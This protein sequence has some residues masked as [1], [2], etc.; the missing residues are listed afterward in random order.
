MVDIV[1][2][3]DS[4][5]GRFGPLVENA[6][7][8]RTQAALDAGV[9]SAIA[10]MSGLA[11]AVAD[12][13]GAKTTTS[14]LKDANVI[15]SASR[16]AITGWYHVDGFGAKGDGATDDRAAIQAALNAANDLYTRNHKRQSVY[17]PPS[18]HIVGAVDYRKADGSIYGAVSLMLPDGV[19]FFGPGTIRVKSGAYGNGALYAIIR[20]SDA[21]VSTASVKGITLDGNRAGNVGSVQCSNIQLEA[22]TDVEVS[23]TYQLNANGNGIMVRGSI[24]RLATNIR[25]NRNTVNGASAIGIQA[26]QFDGLEIDQNN[27]QGTSDNGID[28]YGENGS[29]T[30]SGINWRISR[31]RVRQAPVGIFIESVAHGICEGNDVT[32]CLSECIHVNRINSAPDKVTISNNQLESSPNG[33]RITGDMGSVYI[34]GN[35]IAGVT[36]GGIHM[37]GGGANLSHIYIDS[38]FI[39]VANIN[40]VPLVLIASNT[41]VWSQTVIRRTITQNTNRAYDV[42]N[43]A[44]TKVNVSYDAA[45]T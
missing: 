19:D 41:N 39:D 5:T 45:N 26:S 2:A 34:R 27:V 14:L 30:S 22:K 8:A 1:A 38:N 7:A 33:I 9:Q 44:T 37:G 6:L 16:N 23:E 32:G 28:I 40:Q 42:F 11:D 18:L 29:T 17:L 25:I 12:A 35:T 13:I 3:V 36:T 24:G 21:G 15:P 4:V 10:G 31:N 20:S 43:Y